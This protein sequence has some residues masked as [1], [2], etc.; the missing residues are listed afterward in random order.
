MAFRNPE[1][2]TGKFVLPIY[3]CRHKSRFARTGIEIFL[4][5]LLRAQKMAKKSGA[6]VLR[7]TDLRRWNV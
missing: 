2:P 5:K 6:I 4:K 3:V 1:A 7:N